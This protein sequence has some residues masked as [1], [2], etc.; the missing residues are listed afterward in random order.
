MIEPQIVYRYKSLNDSGRAML[1]NQELYYCSFEQ[2]ND[3]AEGNIEL[4][5]DLLDEDSLRKMLVGLYS[6]GLPNVNTEEVDRQVDVKMKEFLAND[7]QELIRISSL[8]HKQVSKFVGVVSLSSSND[9][10]LLWPHYADGHKGFCMGFHAEL[11]VEVSQPTIC[12]GV[13]YMS[14]VSDEELLPSYEQDSFLKNVIASSFVK[15]SSWAYEEEFRLL[16]DPC[17][18]SERAF[19]FPN[20]IVASIAFGCRMP[21]AEKSVLIPHCK[22]IYPNAV[23][24]QARMPSNKLLIE[25]DEIKA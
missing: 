17:K 19:T 25:F 6:H 4:R 11:L 12:G 8:L 18:D 22:S 2:L 20:D 16:R 21:D 1:L 5:Y 9:N 7:R 10:N 3:P 15:D 14:R 23:L 13:T 24:L